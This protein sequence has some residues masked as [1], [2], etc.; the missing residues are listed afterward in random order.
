MEVY[1]DGTFIQNRFRINILCCRAAIEE[2]KSLMNCPEAGY[3]AKAL[4]SGW[5]KLI[6]VIVKIEWNCPGKL[7]FLVELKSSFV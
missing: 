6:L 1:S 3:C 4:T 7:L 2:Q 5:N